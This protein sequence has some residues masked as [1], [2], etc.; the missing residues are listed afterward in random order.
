MLHRLTNGQLRQIVRFSLIGAVNTGTFYI[1]YRLLLPWMPYFG[2]YTIAFL[3]S[4]LGS[5]FMNTY[6][7][8]RT[9]PT[10][11]KL[12][13]FPLTNMTNFVVQSAGLFALVHLVGLGKQYAP[14]VA[15]MVAIPFT[16]LLSKRI[17]L[18]KED[19]KASARQRSRESA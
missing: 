8:Y 1:F 15:A 14:L 16:Y 6:F 2:A 10:W 5:F 11:K 19:E 4:M 12:L 13:L 18:P 7:T 17:L 3:L 9:R